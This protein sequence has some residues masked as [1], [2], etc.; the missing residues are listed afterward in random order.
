MKAI[1]MFR[2]LGIVT[3]MLILSSYVV[4]TKNQSNY[5]NVSE[6]SFYSS[7]VLLVYPFNLSSSERN[8]RRQCLISS[9]GGSLGPI[10]QCPMNSNAEFV[11]IYSVIINP[12][13]QNNNAAS[14]DDDRDPNLPVYTQN[15]ASQIAE[16]CGL[17]GLSLT[18]DCEGFSP[19][20]PNF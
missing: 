12:G 7:T 16:G 10:E 8:A 15:E 18:L 4:N 1:K 6:D 3:L 17:I 11:T 19:F 20:Q 14:D 5:T 2:V 13:T 9:L